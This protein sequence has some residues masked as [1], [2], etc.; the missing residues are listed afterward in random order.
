MLEIILVLH[1]VTKKHSR[2]PISSQH[3]Q[4]RDIKVVAAT[5]SSIEE[6]SARQ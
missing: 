3:L 6:L 4:V 2:T 5:T 1:Y